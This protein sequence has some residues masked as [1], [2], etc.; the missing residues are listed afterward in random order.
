VAAKDQSV[1]DGVPTVYDAAGRRQGRD[2]L[3]AAKRHPIVNWVAEWDGMPRNQGEKA[4]DKRDEGDGMYSSTATG[5]MSSLIVL[6]YD[7]YTLRHAM[8]LSPDDSIVK[9]LGSL[10]QF[11][12]VRYELAVAAIMVR[13][14]YTIEWI[15]D[16]SRKLPEFLARRGVVEIVA[17]AKSRQRPGVLGKPGDR[18]VEEELKADLGRLLRD[19]LEKETD[20]RPFVVFL[21]LN[22]PPR[23]EPPTEESLKHLHDEVMERRGEA[24]AEHPDPFSA[25][26]FTNFSWHWH[27]TEPSSGAEHAIV[28][29]FYPPCRSRPAR[30]IR[31]R[32]QCSSMDLCPRGS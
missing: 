13:A 17:E 23:G 3:D 20:G 5:N 7:V 10:E 24:S 6:A 22:L 4:L 31:S 12:G 26:V 19:A 1:Y 14:E 30:P 2:K 15:T 28:I 32:K 9:R 18:P 27:D 8:A 29:P 16:V 25:V 21:D 11:H